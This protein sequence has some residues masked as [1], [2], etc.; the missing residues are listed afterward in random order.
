M[1]ERMGNRNKGANT[2]QMICSSGI[3]REPL[4]LVV[5]PGMAHLEHA[6]A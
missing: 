4:Y 5:F 3:P 6:E 2:L 1:Q